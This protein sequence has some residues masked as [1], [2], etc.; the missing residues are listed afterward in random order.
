MVIFFKRKN[1]IFVSIMKKRS[2]RTLGRIEKVDFPELD[3]YGIEAK[4]DTGAYTSSI[5]CESVK[6]TIKEGQEYV[7]FT[8][9]DAHHPL[10][11]KKK[12]T[13]P[14]FA[15]KLIKNSFG[16]AESR[17]IIQTKIIL[18][19]EVYEL[20]LSLADRSL[21]DYPVLLGRKLLRKRFIV[22][23]ARNNCSHKYKMKQNENSGTKSK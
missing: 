14:L 19:E 4:I 2:K 21:M 5:H 12:F 18:F 8:L 1:I 6:S 7:T 17:Y 13:L 10:F 11:H 16:Q 3:L 23:V 9:L 15:E 20:E 22:D